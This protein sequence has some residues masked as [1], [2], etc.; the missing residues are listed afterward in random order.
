ML[1]LPPL[2]GLPLLAWAIPW[3]VASL[4]LRLCGLPAAV[5]SLSSRAAPRVVLAVMALSGWPVA[6]LLRITA[7]GVFNES[8]YFTVQ[9]G[10]LL[11]LFA[12][13]AVAPM[14]TSCPRRALLAAAGAL[15]CLP[16][17]VELVWRKATTPPDVVPARVVAAM[18]AL[19]RSSRRGDVV[20]MRPFSRYPPPPIVLVGRRVPFTQYMPYMRQFASAEVLREREQEVREFFR[21][22]DPV[23]ARSIAHRLGARFVYLFGP[24]SIAPEAEAMLE[25]IYTDGGARLYRVPEG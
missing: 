2:S 17:T 3:L 19:E 18:D 11:W 15:L 10:A 5:R 7:D 16:S 13:I 12:A 20:L 21:T 4:G 25:R 6:L 24:Q 1:Q 14:A 23:E 8:V 9:S 22:T